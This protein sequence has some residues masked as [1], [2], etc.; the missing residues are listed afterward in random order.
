M[1]VSLKWTKN[2]L[3]KG[4]EGETLFLLESE[5]MAFFYVELMH[6]FGSVNRKEDLI[7]T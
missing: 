7:I 3:H 1:G 6:H 5:S 4:N 2:K